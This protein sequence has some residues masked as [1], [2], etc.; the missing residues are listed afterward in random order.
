MEALTSCLAFEED[1]P[2]AFLHTL[3]VLASSHTSEEE[4]PRAFLPALEAL[5][6]CLAFEEDYPRGVITP[7]QE[8]AEC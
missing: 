6:S 8:A 7:R 1:Y 5:T 2:R 3:G 4:Y